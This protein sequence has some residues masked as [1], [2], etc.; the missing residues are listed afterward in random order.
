MWFGPTAVYEGRT[1][2]VAMFDRA[3]V[4]LVSNDER[5]LKK[6][7]KPHAPGIFHKRVTRNN[8]E[9]LYSAEPKAKYRGETF[10][11]TQERGG[12]LLLYASNPK[13][14]WGLTEVERCVWEKW[15][16][17]RD[18]EQVWEDRVPL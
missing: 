9:S 13:A 7:F 17:V 8:L 3:T 1:Y 15:V 18:V 5:D 14:E 6:G 16:S 4:D 11:V 12:M 2:R 10:P